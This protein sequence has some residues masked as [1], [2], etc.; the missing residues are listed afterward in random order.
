MCGLTGIFSTRPRTEASLAADVTA[1]MTTIAHRGPDDAG[2]WVDAEAGVALGF[3]RL[4]II[5]LSPLGHQPMSSASGRFVLS[6]NGEVYN[7]AALRTE[8]EQHGHRFRGQSDT[9]VILA[10]FESWGVAAAVPRFVGMFAMALWDR[11]ER[12]LTLIRDRF[13]KKPL[14][15]YSEPG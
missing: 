14:F 7:Y 1:M 5:D 2:S 4:A 10:A 11:R 8:L 9:E 3:R 6:F 15:V 12:E 13:G